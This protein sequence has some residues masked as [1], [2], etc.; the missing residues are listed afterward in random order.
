M[1]LQPTALRFL[2]LRTLPGQGVRDQIPTNSF[3]YPHRSALRAKERS[4]PTRR[5]K[6]DRL[7]HRNPCAGP[8]S[9]LFAGAFGVGLEVG[10]A[11]GGEAS[12]R[13]VGAGRAARA[14]SSWR[15]GG[16]LARRPEEDEPLPAWQVLETA[17][18]L[19]PQGLPFLQFLAYASPCPKSRSAKSTDRGWMNLIADPPSVAWTLE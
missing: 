1:A 6:Q 18:Q 15:L 9:C 11:F 7:A 8:S 19:P 16:G 5:P 12:G 14:G 17:M 13:G 4:R 10:A 3:K 2:S